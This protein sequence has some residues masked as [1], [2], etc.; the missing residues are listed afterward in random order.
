MEE[1]V[2]EVERLVEG[3]CR[4]V[5]LLGQNVNS[6][7][8]GSARLPQLLQRLN[9]IPD[10]WRIR[11]LTNHPRD[12]TDDILQAMAGLDKVCEHLHLPAQA[13]SD[14]ELARMNRGYTRKHYLALVERAREL[15]PDIGLMS[16]FIVGFPGQ[17]EEEFQATRSLIEEVGYKNC[18]IFRYSPRPGTAASRMPDDVPDPVKQARLEELLET[19]RRVALRANRALIGRLVEV[20][21]EGPSKRARRQNPSSDQAR[22]TTV[23]L[24]GRTRSDHIVVFDGPP[25]LAGTLRTVRI[26]DATDLTLFGALEPGVG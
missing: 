16:D 23:Q 24:V 21:V 8:H 15:M 19:Q 1:I 12:L 17:T 18:F 25:C 9:D 5:I 3:G 26:V 4:E 10:L 20:L 14:S 2:E 22:S 7:R 11:F 13:G 6:Y